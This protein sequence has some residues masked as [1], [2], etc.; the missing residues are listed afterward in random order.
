MVHLEA[1]V[2]HGAEAAEHARRHLDG[3]G[4]RLLEAARS[5]AAFW[6]GLHAR[7][8]SGAVTP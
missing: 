3:D 1:D 4:G 2:E 5:A 8:F 6:I 7:A